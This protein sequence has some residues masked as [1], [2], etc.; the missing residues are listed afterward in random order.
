MMLVGYVFHP[1][2]K[3]MKAHGVTPRA[4]ADDLTI[5][6]TGTGQEKRLKDAYECTFQYLVDIGAKPAP[7]KC[8]TFSTSAETRFRLSMQVWKPFQQHIKVVLSARDLGGTSPPKLSSLG[9][10]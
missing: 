4:L 6:A 8:Y 7:N 3:L 2:V 9:E 5:I 10:R 1:W